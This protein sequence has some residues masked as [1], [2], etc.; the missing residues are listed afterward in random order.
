MTTYE[1][2]EREGFVK[3]QTP[4]SR[5]DRVGV[6]HGVTSNNYLECNSGQFIDTF[7]IT[8][9]NRGFIP[10]RINFCFEFCGPSFTNDTACSS[11]LVAIHLACN[12]L[13]RGDCDTAVAGGTNMCINPDGHTG[14]DKGFFLSKTG[15]CK[16]F[17]DKADGYCRA[18]GVATVIIK[19]LDDVLLDNDPILGVILGAATNHS[20]LSD[21][22]TRPHQG[23]QLE[24]M[25]AV[26][27]SANVDPRELS[28]VEMHGTGTQVGDAVEMQSVLSVFAPD[29]SFRPKEKPL[30]VGTVKDNVCHGEGVSGIISLVK[31]L[32]MMKHDLIPPHCGIKPGSKIN[33]TYP[34][35][36]ARNVHIAFKPTP[37]ERADAPRRCLINNFS[38]AGGNTALLL[39]DAPQLPEITMKDP[40]SSHIVTVSG[41]VAAS[42]KTN[43]R[44]LI[45]Y[46][47]QTDEDTN[48]A[49]LSWTT[50]ARRQHHKH[51]V[52]VTGSSTS[53]IIRAL[54]EALDDGHG[55]TRSK[56]KHNTVFAFT[57]QGSQYLG[58][59]KQLFD[60]VPSFKSEIESLDRLCLSL[61]FPSF[62][63]VIA[64]TEGNVN[65]LPP[66]VIQLATT[67][68]EM[69]LSDYMRVVGLEAKAVVGHSLGEYAALY[70]AGV[71]SAADTLFLVGKR[72]V[73][74]KENCQP[75]THAMLAVKMA[76]DQIHALLPQDGGI[77]CGIACINS[78]TDT[79]ISGEV[80]HLQN[81]R[82]LL[83]KTGVKSTI[84]KTPFA[85]NS[86]QV[87]PVL[88]PF[89]DVATSVTFR[90]PVIPV[91]SPLLEELVANDGVISGPYL[92]RH[93]REAVNMAAGLQ[94][95]QKLGTID[96][97]TCFVEIGTQP[98]V[99]NMAKATLGT[100]VTTSPT[101]QREGTTYPSSSPL[102]TVASRIWTGPLSMSHLKRPTVSCPPCLW[103]GPEGVLDQI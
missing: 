97:N 98:V 95:A 15:N 1:A 39:E 89:T 30:H 16:P 52:T 50:T 63:E 23:G 88:A 8:G 80:E 13:W 56:N 2:L 81:A 61:G 17:D 36:G 21:S 66:V 71:L 33:R 29:E 14:L 73:L 90:K 12:S 19:R 62:K 18:E 76:V 26:L 27:N 40:R 99:C 69:A 10:G 75:G 53:D 87:E 92:T 86:S 72:A 103:L 93:C 32:P 84:L 102:C 101:L 79:V 57:G 77:Q 85:L 51:R 43:V 25:Q 37:W 70:A 4:S 65:D 42:L 22:M 67:A 45:G 82:S 28:Y 47:S 94:A 41:H 64:D 11:S 31:V 55:V 100:Q 59:G 83:G 74:L 6:F 78:P 35:L 24:S 60:T 58:M 48:L 44:K 68:L 91:I 96:D 54:Q 7:F 9:G 38:A 20:A 34:D 49:Q 5:K 46:L 3:D